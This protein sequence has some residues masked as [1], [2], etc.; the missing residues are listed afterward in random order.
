MAT[1]SS[2]DMLSDISIATRSMLGLDTLQEAEG[3]IMTLVP[4]L[5]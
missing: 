5:P 2:L 3:S 4:C 1:R